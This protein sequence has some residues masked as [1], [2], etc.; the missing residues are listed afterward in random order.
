MTFFVLQGVRELR[1]AASET[2]LP[3]RREPRL[4]FPFRRA[5][6]ESRTLS[7][8]QKS[9]RAE[10]APQKRLPRRVPP[11]PPQPGSGYRMATIKFLSGR[12][13]GEGSNTPP[14]LDAAGGLPQTAGLRGRGD[15]GESGTSRVPLPEGRWEAGKDHG[16]NSHDG[17]GRVPRFLCNQREQ[18]DLRLTPPPRPGTG[19]GA[20]AAPAYHQ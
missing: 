20:A 12:E 17:F 4:S 1:S 18:S 6:R 13:K 10:A 8:V 16:A 19:H 14:R 7:S 2:P 9:S 3:L 11:F 15:A 5:P